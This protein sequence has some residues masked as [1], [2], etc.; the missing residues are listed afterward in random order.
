MPKDKMAK[1][2]NAQRQN[3]KCIKTKSQ[4]DKMPKDKMAKRQNA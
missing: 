2:Q 1:R 4:K 3:D